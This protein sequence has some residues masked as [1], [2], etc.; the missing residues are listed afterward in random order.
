[1]ELTGG[2]K[3][4]VYHKSNDFEVEDCVEIKSRIGDDKNPPKMK[5]LK[6]GC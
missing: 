1:V 4:T 3:L 2:E 6:D 5:R